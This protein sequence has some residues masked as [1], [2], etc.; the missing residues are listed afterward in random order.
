MLWLLL[1]VAVWNGFF[2]LYISRGAHEYLQRVA[3]AEVGRG[4]APSMVDV[5]AHARHLGLVASTGWAVLVVGAGWVTLAGGRR[6][7]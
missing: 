4:P 1:G 7:A 3:E 6:R 5:M 2:D